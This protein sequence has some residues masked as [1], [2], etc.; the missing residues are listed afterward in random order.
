M[1]ELT[2][3]IRHAR[4]AAG[5]GGADDDPGL[6]ET[7][8]AQAAVVAE[9]LG[10][11]AI[12][13][14]PRRIISSPLRRCLETAAPLAATT[15]L[16]VE[17]NASVGEIPTPRGLAR[18]G[19]GSWL[20]AA[21]AARWSDIRGDLDYEA[22]RQAIFASVAA[23]PGAAIFSHFVAINAVVTLLAGEDQ[24]ITFRPDH[25]SITTLEVTSDGLRLVERGRE[26]AT[27]VL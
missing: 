19:R 4:P 16:Q 13:Q 6:D 14:R 22:W 8:R 25:A 26:A 1:A 2:W 9:T 24:V 18:E 3:L 20:R 12:A 15:G 21:L 23:A 7:G 11:L 27:G 10:G 17:V 5:W